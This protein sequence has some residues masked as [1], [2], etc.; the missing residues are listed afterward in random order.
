MIENETC[1]ILYTKVRIKGSATFLVF[2]KLYLFYVFEGEHNKL[3]YIYTSVV[4]EGPVRDELPRLEPV[5]QR[6]HPP[7]TPEK[8]VPPGAQ[9]AQLLHASLFG[10][11]ILEPNLGTHIKIYIY[12][13]YL[14]LPSKHVTVLWRIFCTSIFYG[15]EVVGV[16]WVADDGVAVGGRPCCGL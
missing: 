13:C 5:H 4:W 2:F 9:R 7:R 14:T 8:C 1:I 16:E 12:I 15:P 3:N 11:S 6:P 10:T